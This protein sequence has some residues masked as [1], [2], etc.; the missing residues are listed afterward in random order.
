[1]RQCRATRLLARLRHAWSGDLLPAD[2]GLRPAIPSSVLC[3]VLPSP[4]S[5][6]SLLFHYSAPLFLSHSLPFSLSFFFPFQHRVDSSEPQPHTHHRG[7]LVDV[8]ESRHSSQGLHGL[9]GLRTGAF[10]VVSSLAQ[11]ASKHL[12]VSTSFTLHLVLI[13]QVVDL[14]SRTQT[15][16]RG[17]KIQTSCG[18][19][20]GSEVTRVLAVEKGRI[21][22]GF[23]KTK[24]KKKTDKKTGA[25]EK[26]SITTG[27]NRSLA[28]IEDKPGSHGVVDHQS[29]PYKS[30]TYS[31]N[32]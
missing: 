7:F 11:I 5:P 16:K 20:T 6:I 26:T 31:K 12:Q 1:M 19:S 17:K 22:P 23:E 28:T 24:N 14:G 8:K 3:F 25:Q 10:V 18:S 13:V 15:K 29:G 30:L 4:P 9:G 32:L 21:A 27:R 2:C